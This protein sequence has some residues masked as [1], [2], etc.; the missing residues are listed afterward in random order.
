MTVLSTTLLLPDM[1]WQADSM[2]VE[3]A[4]FECALTEGIEFDV[5]HHLATVT[6]ASPKALEEILLRLAEAGYP[7]STA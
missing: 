4:A 3:D 6:Y 2:E 1:K 5:E 7:A